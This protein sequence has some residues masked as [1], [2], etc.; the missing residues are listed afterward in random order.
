VF[1]RVRPGPILSQSPYLHILLLYDPFHLRLDFPAD[2]LHPGFTTKILYAFLISS[3]RV[4][5]LARATLLDFII[6]WTSGEEY[7]L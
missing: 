6:S 1:I 3:M 5:C 7:H 2:L 4:A